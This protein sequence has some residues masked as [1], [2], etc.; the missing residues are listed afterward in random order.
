VMTWVE[1]VVQ[2]ALELL[3]EHLVVVHLQS[4]N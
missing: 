2:E 1:Q 3:L 4:L